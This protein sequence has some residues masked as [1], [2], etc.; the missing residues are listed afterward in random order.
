LNGSLRFAYNT[1]GMQSH[2]L[3]EA[4]DLLHESG[5]SGVALTLDHM[6]LDPLRAS[7]EAIEAVGQMLKERDLAL[8]IETGA[9]YVLDPRRKHRPSW[10]EK[11]TEARQQRT[12]Y[13]LRCLDIA[14]QLRAESVVLFSGVNHDQMSPQEA[15]TVFLKELGMVVDKASDL[16][17]PLA[18]EPE[19][20]HLV[21]TLP[22]F[23]RCASSYPSLGLALDVGHVPVTEPNRS[24]PRTIIDY[25]DKLVAVHFEDSHGELHEHLPF[26]Q[27][28][29]NHRDMLK[30]LLDIDYQGLVSVEL[31]RHSHCAH[32]LVPE[33]MTYLKARLRG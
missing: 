9:R 28:S 3:D 8:S 12:R 26:G 22:D 7:P 14:S 19:P 5:Y 11:K 18:L 17:I 32:E 20:G 31:S 4:L 33:S 24:I 1:N 16:E 15:W 23:D 29:L 6:H 2:R 27:G 13:L 25:A 21:A 30:A 10:I